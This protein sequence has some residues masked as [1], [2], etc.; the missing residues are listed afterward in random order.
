MEKKFDSWRKSIKRSFGRKVG[1]DVALKL[2]ELQEAQQSQAQQQQQAQQVEQKQN[3]PLQQAEDLLA[4]PKNIGTWKTF[5]RSL[6]RKLGLRVRD[7]LQKDAE[8]DE[9][10]QHG[11]GAEGLLADVGPV[12]VMS[13]QQAIDAGLSF[14]E[15]IR[16]TAPAVPVD[17]QAEPSTTLPPARYR[18]RRARLASDGA[19]TRLPVRR[20][21]S[22]VQ[23]TANTSKDLLHDLGARDLGTTPTTPG[24]PHPMEVVAP[25]PT[26]RSKYATW[27]ARAKPF[28][29][30]DQHRSA[31]TLVPL[32]GPSRSQ[33]D[34]SCGATSQI[35]EGLQSTT[36]QPKKE[37]A[38]RGRACEATARVNDDFSWPSSSNPG[39]LE[40]VLFKPVP[41]V[42]NRDESRCVY[43]AS[44]VGVVRGANVNEPEDENLLPTQT[45]EHVEE[46]FEALIREEEEPPED[47]EDQA[48][49][50]R[51]ALL[52]AVYSERRA[53]ALREHREARK[54]A[55][56]VED[57]QAAI[58]SFNSNGPVPDKWFSSRYD[59]YPGESPAESSTAST[60]A[61]QL[62]NREK[63]EARAEEVRNWF[64]EWERKKANGATYSAPAVGKDTRSA[65]SLRSSRPP[66]IS[67]SCTPRMRMRSREQTA[68]AS[69]PNHRNS[70][71]IDGWTYSARRQEQDLILSEPYGDDDGLAAIEEGSE[72]LQAESADEEDNGE[73]RSA[74]GLGS[75]VTTIWRGSAGRPD[76]ETGN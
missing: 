39:L 50:I 6:G 66:V 48:A 17:L 72:D 18:V 67:S 34:V 56:E 71:V 68:H 25:V 62:R 51:R 59:M 35:S 42:L 23:I 53:A 70:V 41:W 13:M 58:G 60:P 75:A 38:Q 24:Y 22:A 73:S 28:W 55:E 12:S 57:L 1:R 49:F 11:Q 14:E 15:A 32:P 46:E 44:E 2:Q 52:G 30:C 54:S 45:D 29:C 10:Q 65:S 20:N 64:A 40:P 8:L 7:E 33:G 63:P 31:D 26:G 61:Y 19:R 69:A 4:S 5:K 43:G 76:G 27:S 37:S 47:S 74:S 3:Q 16:A 9:Q 21:A 36:S